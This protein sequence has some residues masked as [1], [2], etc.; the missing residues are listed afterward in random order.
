MQSGTNKCFC[1]LTL[2]SIV[3]LWK[4]LFES[5]LYIIFDIYFHIDLKEH[6]LIN[7][8]N[9]PQPIRLVLISHMFGIRAKCTT[10]NFTLH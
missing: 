2:F 8:Y 4:H 3:A 5:H 10:L 6:F 1:L 9:F 7:S